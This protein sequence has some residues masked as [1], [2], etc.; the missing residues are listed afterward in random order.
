MDEGV[1]GLV[2]RDWS[3]RHVEKMLPMAVCAETWG[4]LAGGEEKSA[5]WR[6]VN[7]G[8]CDESHGSADGINIVARLI[9]PFVDSGMGVVMFRA[10][11]RSAG[12][13]GIRR[14]SAL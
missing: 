14:K 11:S 2:R 12:S 4:G 9:L 6:R 8:V 3:E 5:V 13:S 10:W 7:G 1:A